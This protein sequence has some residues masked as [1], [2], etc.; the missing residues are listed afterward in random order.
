MTA[1]PR[2]LARPVALATLAALALTT[3]AACSSDD[4]QPVA[5]TSS[6]AEAPSSAPTSLDAADE[7]GP[8]TTAPTTASSAEPE[9]D[10]PPTTGA[11]GEVALPLEP[12]PTSPNATDPAGD[13]CSPASADV[14]PDGTWFG[15]LRSA[16]PGTATFGLDLACFFTAEAAD[17]AALAD[18]PTT[19]VPVPNGVHI[20]NQA[21]TVYPLVEDGNATV[22]LLDA[23][24]G[25]GLLPPVTGFAAAAPALDAWPGPVNV[26]VVVQ[27]GQV[28]LLQQQ[29]LP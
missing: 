14:L 22:Y 20:R 19:E 12:P 10:G 25:M 8:P 28:V 7:D 1:I 9:E 16:G 21:D 5:A 6:V 3:T 15:L 11:P 26:W 4:D 27:G 23:A 29:Y 17:A 18:D 24:G 13:G 2:P